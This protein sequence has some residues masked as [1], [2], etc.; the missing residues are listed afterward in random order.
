MEARRVRDGVQARTGRQLPIFSFYWSDYDGWRG[1][2]RRVFMDQADLESTIVRPATVWGING[3]IIWGDSADCSNGTLCGDGP[4]S[5]STF[6]DTGA[7]RYN[8]SCAHQ[9]CM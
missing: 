9:I 5:I 3:M 8:R 1:F 7:C 4:A 6:L 2:D